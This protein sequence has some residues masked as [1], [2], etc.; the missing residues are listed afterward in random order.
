MMMQDD[1]KADPDLPPIYAVKALRAGRDA[2]V[3]A[4]G[5]AEAGDPA[6]TF[7][8]ARRSDC[9][10]LAVVL[11]PDHPRVQSVPVCLVAMVAML[12][13]LG[14]VIEP[15]VGVTFGWPDRIDVNG[16]LVGGLRLGVA[17]CAAADDVPDWMVIGITIAVSGDLSDDSPGLKPDRTTLFDEGCGPV[18]IID[19]LERF[20][21]Y[22]LHW[23]NRWQEDGL[24]PVRH[25]WLGRESGF[26]EETAIYF[27]RERIAGHFAK[28]DEFGNAV[29]DID[30]AQRV[31][32]LDAAMQCGSWSRGDLLLARHAVS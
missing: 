15:S 11:E 29:L 30:G 22:L 3:E 23:M 20:G 25:A 19:F 16:A 21:R 31:F 9:I 27:N 32:A 24:D 5:R 17:P 13:A 8:W 4:V 2:F 14:G 10:D 12:D 26:G 28:L 1:S 7:L 18:D 6:G